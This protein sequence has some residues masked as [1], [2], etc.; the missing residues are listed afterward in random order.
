MITIGFERVELDIV[1]D[2][3]T[4]GMLTDVIG[5]YANLS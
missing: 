5:R 2:N 3:I 4:F 1:G